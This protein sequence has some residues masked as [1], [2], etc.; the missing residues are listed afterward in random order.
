M[1]TQCG[2]PQTQRQWQRPAPTPV[3]APHQCPRG[4]F[5]AQSAGVQEKEG[6]KGLK[7]SL[8][9]LQ[10]QRQR[11][12]K[13]PV[14]VPT[15]VP[16]MVP[17]VVRR[18]GMPQPLTRRR[19]R[20]PPGT[21]VGASTS[22][23]TSARTG[24]AR[25]LLSAFPAPWPKS[26]AIRRTT[27][28]STSTSTVTPTLPMCRALFKKAGGTSRMDSRIYVGWSTKADTT[29]T[30]RA[31]KSSLHPIA[32]SSS[33]PTGTAAFDQPLGSGTRTGTRRTAGENTAAKM[34]TRPRARRMRHIV[35]PLTICPHHNQPMSLSIPSN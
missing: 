3:T 18:A 11:Q 29:T 12:C 27:R 5:Q 33:D 20:G 31:F 19:A 28:A 21:L 35:S 1:A 13:P 34:V 14:S 6:S 4:Q 15:R 23:S 25:V 7:A 24:G 32:R 10:R 22:H 17:T 2:S 30:S 8:Q 26:C 16:T 9:Q